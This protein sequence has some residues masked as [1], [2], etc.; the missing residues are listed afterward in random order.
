MESYI[1]KMFSGERKPRKTYLKCDSGPTI[2]R[3]EI[4]RAI[5]NFGEK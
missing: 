4:M 3:N 1:T 5:K 2:L